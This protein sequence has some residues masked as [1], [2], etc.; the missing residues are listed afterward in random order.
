MILQ[1]LIG[2]VPQLIKHEPLINEVLAPLEL[3]ST[4]FRYPLA[5]IIV[6]KFAWSVSLNVSGLATRVWS[7]STKTMILYKN[8]LIVNAI[9]N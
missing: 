9:G 4:V 8:D 2:F 1:V 7:R 5:S 6:S 3:S